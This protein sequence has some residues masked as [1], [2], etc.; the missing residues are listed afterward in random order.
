[1]GLDFLWHISNE[2]I[3]VAKQELRRKSAFPSWSLGTREYFFRSARQPQV[4][5]YGINS[6]AIYISYP[7]SHHFVLLFQVI[8]AKRDQPELYG[9]IYH[10]TL[11]MSVSGGGDIISHPLSDLAYR[12]SALTLTMG[13]S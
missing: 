3:E 4:V 2:K 6:I 5:L 12:E 11:I 1:M 13:K 9:R 7:Q 10:Y 8:C